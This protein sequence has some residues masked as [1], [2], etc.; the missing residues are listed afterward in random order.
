MSRNSYYYNWSI[1]ECFDAMRDE[2]APIKKNQHIKALTISAY[3]ALS[4]TRYVLEM[5]ATLKGS[6]AIVYKGEKEEEEGKKRRRLIFPCISFVRKPSL[7][8]YTSPRYLLSSTSKDRSCARTESPPSATAWS[9]RGIVRPETETRWV[10]LHY[11]EKETTTTPPS[12][13]SSRSI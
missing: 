5:P 12:P 1:P 4:L 13:S 8:T 7:Y 2:R 3:L 11:F 6:G 10:S 9:A